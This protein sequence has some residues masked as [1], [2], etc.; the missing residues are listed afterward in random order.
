MT[1]PG[2][3]SLGIE[4]KTAVVSGS[5]R[6]AGLA[7]GL[8]LAGAGARVVLNYLS[9]EQKA[10]DALLKFQD[11]GAQA[12]A[13]RADVVKVDEAGKLVREA[14]AAFGGID[15]LVNNAHGRIVRSAFPKTTWEDHQAQMEGIL[16]GAYNLTH[17]VIDGMRS[18]GFGR[19]VNMGNNMLLQPIKGYSAYTSSMAALL[20]FTRNLAAEAGPWGITVNM[21][22]PGFVAT[23]ESPNTTDS[24]RAAIAESTPLKRLATPEDV[25]GAVLFFCSDLGRFVT[26]ANLSVDGGKVMS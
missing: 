23:E 25:A 3:L 22:S 11:I 12:V 24:V 4:G 14:E 26:G 16:K 2:L 1:G 10:R 5:T 18:R 8:A 21:V 7:I 6:G 9:D 13:V 20:G 15:I 17:A 19:V